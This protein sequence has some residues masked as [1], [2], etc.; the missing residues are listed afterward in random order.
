MGEKK[1]NVLVG[2]KELC[3]AWGVSKDFLEKARTE[4][5]LPAYK[6][7]G[8]IKYDVA[9]VNAWKKERKHNG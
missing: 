1:L 8:R 3:E 4:M 2:T 5:G 6:I 7:G 9:E